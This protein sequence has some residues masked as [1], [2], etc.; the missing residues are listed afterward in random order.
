MVNEI[1]DKSKDTKNDKKKKSIWYTI[2]H[3]QTLNEEEYL[4]LI[5]RLTYFIGGGFAVS[6][7]IFI[8]LAYLGGLNKVINIVE[9]ANLTLYFLEMNYV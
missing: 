5:R 7:L 9:S 1:E 4:H 2:L 8:I 3:I 6:F